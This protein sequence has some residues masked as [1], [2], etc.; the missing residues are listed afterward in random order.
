M[1][2]LLLVAEFG[3]TANKTRFRFEFFGDNDDYTFGTWICAHKGAKWNGRLRSNRKYRIVEGLSEFVQYVYGVAITNTND[4]LRGVAICTGVPNPII[5][6]TAEMADW[7]LLK[8]F[9]YNVNFKGMTLPALYHAYI[10][11]FC[12][13]LPRDAVGDGC[14]VVQTQGFRACRE[15]ELHHH[16]ACLGKAMI[17][18]GKNSVGLEIPILNK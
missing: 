5:Q 7:I 14:W 6:E 11:R 3:S 12:K 16:R 17:R 15:C 9:Q 4:Y 13:D 2:Q 10:G 8:T 1:R 18:T